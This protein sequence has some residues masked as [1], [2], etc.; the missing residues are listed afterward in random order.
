MKSKICTTPNFV[1]NSSLHQQALADG[2][3]HFSSWSFN[4]EDRFKGKEVSSIKE[5]LA[6]TAFPFAVCFE[7]WIH[8]FNIASGIRN[9][10]AFNTQEVFYVGY[11]KLDRRGMCGVHNYTQVTW[12][13]SLDD[14]LKLKGQYTFVGIDNVE[15]AVPLDSYHWKPNSM[16]IFGS[17]GVGLSKTMLDHCDDIV[18]IKQY[19][20]VR[21]LNAAT[22]SGIIMNDFVT[23]YNSCT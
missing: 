18:Y 21:S 2:T 15:G 3:D 11:K 17:E 10:N 6:R 12:L 23:K 14:L 20:S 4:V 16:M 1:E 19:G 9:A 22:A 13:P 5:E 7:N 8:D